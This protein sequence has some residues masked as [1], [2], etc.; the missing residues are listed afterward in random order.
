[1]RAVL[2]GTPGTGKTSVSEKVEGREIL[3]LSEFVRERGLGEE[4]EVFDVRVSEMVEEVVEY[5]SGKDII[6]EGHL[7]HHVP[8]DHCIVLRCEPG[9][10]RKRLE[11]RNYPEDKIQVNLESEK[12]DTMLQEALNVQENVFE[13]DTTHRAVEETAEEV[14]EVLE[15]MKTGY[16]EVDW[17]DS[18]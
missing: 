9:E 18:I 6:I 8:A 13:I 14:E 5:S 7:A 4:G 3:H 2:T 11:K 10:L 1:V 15:Q 12:L 16:G 17:S